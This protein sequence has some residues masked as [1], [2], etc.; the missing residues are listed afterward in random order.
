MR[1]QVVAFI[2]LEGV[3]QADALERHIIAAL[4]PVIDRLD[5]DRGDVIGQQNDLVRVDLIAELVLQLLGRDQA[6]LQQPGDEGAGA[7][8]G[9]DDVDA[10]GAEGLAEFGL[11]HLVH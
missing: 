9:V 7:G 1:N 4:Q 11:Q 8:E 5:V 10:G 3:G 6:G 2:H